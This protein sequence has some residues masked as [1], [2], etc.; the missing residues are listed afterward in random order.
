V[1][2]LKELKIVNQR[3]KVQE[4]LL[5]EELLHIGNPKRFGYETHSIST[6]F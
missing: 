4:G 2:I 3:N 1:P 6:Y 5:P